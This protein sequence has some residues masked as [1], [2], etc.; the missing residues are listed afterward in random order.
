MGARLD[1]YARRGPRR[2]VN[3]VCSEEVLPLQD[4]GKVHRGARLGWELIGLKM[5]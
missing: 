2:W 1:L 3:E 4:W 5:S